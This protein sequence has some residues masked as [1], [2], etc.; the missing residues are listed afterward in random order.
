MF[1]AAE[2]D[3]LS[4]IQALQ[5]STLQLIFLL[6]QQTEHLGMARKLQK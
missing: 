6:F 1:V 3:R 5:G 4:L 2:T